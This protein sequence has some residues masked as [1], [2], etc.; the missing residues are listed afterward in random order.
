MVSKAAH[1][2]TKNSSS[3]LGLSFARE[4]TL[5]WFSTLLHL[6]VPV[7]LGDF[8]PF[9]HFTHFFTTI[10]YLFCLKEPQERSTLY[11]ASSLRARGYFCRIFCKAT[12]DLR[13][14]RA[15]TKE[16]TKKH[17]K[18]LFSRKNGFP[19]LKALHYKKFTDLHQRCLTK[20]GA[21][22][23]F[24]GTMAHLS[25]TSGQRGHAFATQFLARDQLETYSSKH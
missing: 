18:L 22:S 13:S 14:T 1:F 6:I 23:N 19:R 20:K 8:R 16:N 3:A 5:Y 11:F 21:I 2:A 12:L 24:L 15:S 7:V 4:S 9:F 25:E 10:S 17:K